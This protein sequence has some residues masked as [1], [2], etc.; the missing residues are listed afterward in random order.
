[1]REE[2]GIQGWVTWRK[3][4]ISHQK[5]RK[6]ESPSRSIKPNEYLLRREVSR[7]KKGAK[8]PVK[9]GGGKEEII[10]RIQ[11]QIRGG[12]QNCGKG[13]AAFVPSS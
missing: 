11:R 1:V 5:R 10:R 12:T 8:S 2:L 6:R 4:N 13:A 7:K 3:G 9:Q